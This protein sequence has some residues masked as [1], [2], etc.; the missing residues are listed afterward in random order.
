MTMHGDDDNGE[1][2]ETS[3]SWKGASASSGGS[4][5]DSEDGFADREREQDGL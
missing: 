2:E 5:E 1:A 4:N 3:A